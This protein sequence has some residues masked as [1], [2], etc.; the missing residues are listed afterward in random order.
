MTTQPTFQ[1]HSQVFCGQINLAR[2]RY[3]SDQFCTLLANI[4]GEFIF[5][6]TEPWLSKKGKVTGLPKNVKL[7]YVS[8]KGKTRA[9]IVA[10]NGVNLW[11]RHEFSD[12]DM[13]T[14]SWAVTDYREDI[15]VVSAYCD[16]KKPILSTVAQ[17]LMDHVQNDSR[18]LLFTCDS[19][20]HSVI[21]NSV[22]NQREARGEA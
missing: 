10:S 20:S 12:N 13:V 17:K 6:L 5:F 8:G 22:L 3:S 2:S 19:N 15:F 14:C 4:K 9:A 1:D 11:L 16:V 21:W 18:Q 7:Y